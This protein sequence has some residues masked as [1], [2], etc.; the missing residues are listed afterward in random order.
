MLGCRL[1]SAFRSADFS[2]QIPEANLNVYRT[3]PRSAL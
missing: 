3:P 2:R 1:K